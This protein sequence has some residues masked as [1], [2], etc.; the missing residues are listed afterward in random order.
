MQARA[1]ILEKTICKSVTATPE[2]LSAVLS[3]YASGELKLAVCELRRTGYQ[4]KVEGI[5]AR[6]GGQR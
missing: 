2:M 4:N 3:K 1:D 6:V 5:L